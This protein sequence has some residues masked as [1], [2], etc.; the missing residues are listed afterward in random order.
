MC[1]N[2]VYR[3]IIAS[4]RI[5]VKEKTESGRQKTYFGDGRFG[6]E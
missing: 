2:S 6:F 4:L 1:K 5:V 3:V